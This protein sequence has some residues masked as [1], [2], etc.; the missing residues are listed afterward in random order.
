MALKKPLI[1]A[2][3]VCSLSTAQIVL[4]DGVKSSESQKTAKSVANG[5]VEPATQPPPL[6]APPAS[7]KPLQSGK[8]GGKIAETPNPKRSPGKAGEKQSQIQK[9]V[10][11]SS[12]EPKLIKSKS[13]IAIETRAS[14]SSESAQGNL[15]AE[16]VSL[17]SGKALEGWV[18]HEGQDDAWSREG[19]VISCRGA[20]GG[21]IR[22][23]K[24]YSD[25]HM[26][27][28]YRYHSGCNT[29]VGIRCPSEGNPT[30]T[31]IEIQL[32][33]DGA[34]KY[35]NL[36]AD[37][38][39]G[40]IYY[41]VAPSQKPKL[42]SPQEWNQ[43]EVICISDQL[44][45]KINGEIVN[46]INLARPADNSQPSSSKHWKLAE[47]PPIGHLAL[48]GHPS[49]VDFRNLFV[50]DLAVET[51][52]G[53][54]YVNITDGQ[55]EPVTDATTITIH[56]VGQL[57]NGT[58]FGDTRDFGEPVTVAF[59]EVI[60]GW[61]HGIIGMK[62]GGRRRLIVPPEMAYG[63]EGVENLIPPDSTLVFEVELRG[64]ER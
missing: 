22:T 8:D 9:T 61:K 63:S 59:D 56:Y 20:G 38:Y 42:K 30:F 37:Q 45:I 43:C 29:G 15:P 52:S 47:R 32:L 16:F 64:F 48:Q 49:Q 55:G 23:E 33:D 40:S 18:V 11:L 41:Q 4:S 26:K 25:F 35:K 10:K 46:E 14:T 1:I 60:D 57:R 50:K 7:A 34:E 27:F 17:L 53:V 36:R 58:R 19:D 28:D 39:T 51:A 6:L 12:I 13:P 2:G 44:T 54:R 31:G 3:I 5:E 21:W 62:V 24:E